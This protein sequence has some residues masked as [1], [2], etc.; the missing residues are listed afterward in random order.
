MINCSE[1]KEINIS[2]QENNKY[3]FERNGVLFF[4]HVFNSVPKLELKEK[5][6]ANI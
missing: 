4:F 6:S 1:R 3:L 5:L 2:V